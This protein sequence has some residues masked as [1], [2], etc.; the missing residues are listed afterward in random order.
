MNKTSF[1]FI[2]LALSLLAN[3]FVAGYVVS[4]FPPRHG[5]GQRGALFDKAEKALTH[6]SP[7]YQKQVWDIMQEH[8]DFITGHFDERKKRFDAVH[9]ILTAPV[10]D[11]K[12]LKKAMDQ[13]DRDDVKVSVQKMLI[14]I[15]KIL[16]D[17]ERIRFFEESAP[18]PGPGGPPPFAGDRPP[19]GPPLEE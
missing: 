19:A 7:Q 10:F 6:V 16:P 8:R 18:G 13:I 15:A 11:E 1:L 17:D 14:S 2:A 4:G 12:A 5:G 9:K 3:A